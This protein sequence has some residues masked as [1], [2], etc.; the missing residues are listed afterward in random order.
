MNFNINI[1]DVKDPRTYIVLG[2]TMS[3]NPI[4]NL[5]L[6]YLDNILLLIILLEKYI[7]QQIIIDYLVYLWIFLFI[8]LNKFTLKVE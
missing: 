6:S 5:C 1:N 4:I 2:T 8:L 3:H 7:R